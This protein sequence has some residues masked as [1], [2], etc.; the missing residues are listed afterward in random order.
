MAKRG[1]VLVAIMNDKRDFAIA[2][3]HNW[4]RIPVSSV[5]KWLNDRWPPKKIAF[6]QTKVFG[7]EAYSIRYFAKV[8]QIKERSRRQLFP[9]EP[10][11]KKSQRRYY[12]LF[13]SPLQKLPKPIFS[14]RWRR[15]VF[16]ATVEE[17]FHQAV[18]INDLYDESPL[19]DRLWAELKRYNI[20]AERQEFVTL[21]KKNYFLDFA[22]YCEKG[23]LNIETD[24][25]TWHANSESAA[26]DNVRDNALQAIGWRVLRFTTNQ[27]QESAEGYCIHKVSKAINNLGGVNEDKIV[28]RKINAKPDGSYQLSLFDDIK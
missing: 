23:N 5:K 15:I 22:I 26:K 21:D 9:S 27:I 3:D 11:G 19:E 7:D 24:G 1:E 12:K 17:K 2:R 4:Y 18:E 6:Y 16:I 14:R 28:P 10:E 20:P 13:L 25:D 8:I